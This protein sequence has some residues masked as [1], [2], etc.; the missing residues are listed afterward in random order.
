MFKKRKIGWILPLLSLF[1]FI[2]TGCGIGNDTVTFD[3]VHGLGYSADGEQ[4]VI[5]AH[6]GFISYSDGKWTIPEGEKHDYMGLSMTEEG[7]YSSGHPAKGSDLKD[8]MG[9]VKSKD[10]LGTNL[11]ILS[12]HGEVDFHHM[13]AGYQS[14]VIYVMN[15][16]PNSMMK[17]SGLYYTE[18]EAQTWSKSEMTGV[19]GE[20]FILAVHPTHPQFIAIGTEKGLFL[21]KD[22]GNHFET[23]LPKQITSLAYNTVGE[24]FVGGYDGK[25][26]LVQ[27]DEKVDQFQTIQLPK[28]ENDAVQYFG[29]NPL[30]ED[31]AVFISYNKN[32][33]LSKDFGNTWEMIA[34]EGKGN[35]LD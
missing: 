9:I 15:E 13:A 16:A 17:S 19:E 21:S 7:F 2:L 28:M 23:I 18:D 32:I 34:E 27:Y 10:H 29:Q 22:H 31:E 25:P 1:V 24:L 12:L 26:F 5:P 4:I 14:N 35:S 11:E 20:H 33:F 8:P 3:H 6:H 30:K